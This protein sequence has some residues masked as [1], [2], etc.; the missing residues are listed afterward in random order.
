MGKLFLTEFP[1]VFATEPA[2][3]GQG[4]WN[5]GGMGSFP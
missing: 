2:A 5:M 4:A 1:A 3:L